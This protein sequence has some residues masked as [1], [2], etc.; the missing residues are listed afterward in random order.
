MLSTYPPRGVPGAPPPRGGL[1]TPQGGLGTPPRGVP[2]QVP[3]PPGGVPGQVPPA[4]GPGTP[5]GGYLVRYPPWGGTRFG[6]QGVGGVP[7]QV[8]RVQVRYPEGALITPPGGTQSGTPPGGYPDPPSLPCGQ[9]NT[10]E[11][12]TFPSYY[13][14]ITILCNWFVQWNLRF[15]AT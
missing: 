1:G 2:G 5:P 9:T 6:T 10:C 8:F 12:S 15:T 14:H 11:N 4:G 7:S 3:L 13:V